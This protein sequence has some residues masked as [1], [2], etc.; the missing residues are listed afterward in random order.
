MVLRA[1]DLSVVA[2]GPGVFDRNLLCALM[3][4]STR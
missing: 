4:A 3:L 1:L 2:Q